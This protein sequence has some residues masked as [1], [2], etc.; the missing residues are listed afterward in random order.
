MDGEEKEVRKEKE[1]IMAKKKSNDEG[2]PYFKFFI[3]KWSTGNIQQCSHASQGLFINLCVLY[4][5][6]RGELY[7][8]KMQKRF[9]RKQKQF[10]ELISEDVIK[11]IED[12]IEISFLDEQLQELGFV[13]EQNRKN[14]FTRW[15]QTKQDATALP[16]DSERSANAM[17]KEEIRR[18]EKREEE[19]EN[20]HAQ[21]FQRVDDY[22]P[23][24]V[25]VALPDKSEIEKE[26]FSDELFV[27]D[28]RRNHPK[29]SIQRA[30]EECWLYHSQ[31]PSPPTLGWQWRQKLSTWLINMKDE[32]TS[33]SKHD[34]TTQNLNDLAIIEQH[35][36]SG[37][38]T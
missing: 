24:G 30:W 11:I 20:A 15:N 34:R 29:K 16:S 4:W 26:I 12:E 6:Q 23:R 13:S 31:K 14:A 10:A 27:K 1:R 25:S 18:E 33:K 22:V 2:L 19:S 7:L 38:D 17:P 5:G 37:G 36:R 35:L 28:L 3:S 21:T 8:S 9:P 32:R